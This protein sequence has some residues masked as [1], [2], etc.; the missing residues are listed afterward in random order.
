MM[1]K[2]D[3]DQSKL[4][5]IIG[6]G[7]SGTSLLQEIMNTYEGFCNTHES[8]VGSKKLSCYSYVL[9]SNDF[10]Y[11]E[12][13]MRLNWSD[14][15]FVE[16]TP[17][18][19]LCLPQLSE[20]YPDANYIFLE[21]NPLKIIL[22]QMNFHPPGRKD[23]KTRLKQLWQGNFAGK[24]L[25]LNFEQFKAKQILKRVESQVTH[26]SKFCNQI[27]IKYED[28]IENLDSHL[29]LIKDTFNVTPDIPLA[30]QT[31]S[32]PSKSSKKNTYKFTSLS[33]HA[34]IDMTRKA[35]ELWGYEYA[36]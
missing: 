35:C 16:K 32:T 2:P 22:S 7:R 4:F 23:I 12:D 24:D 8:R 20:R 33:D 11:L 15:F 9:K 27:T 6:I 31:L 26:K 13:F 14:E 19:I 36:G 5:F 10:S 18:S 25:V 30:K 28:L 3:I 17:N 21:R 1:A 34:A 29:M